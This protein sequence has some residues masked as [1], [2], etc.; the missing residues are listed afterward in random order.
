MSIQTNIK[1][2]AVGVIIGVGIMGVVLWKS[3]FSVDRYATVSL[4]SGGLM[5]GKI[6]RFPRTT[7][8]DPF[9]V[10]KDQE[11][12]EQLVPLR[13]APW[14]PKDGIVYLNDDMIMNWSY[15]DP[16]GELVQQMKAPPSQ[17]S[18][19]SGPS[20]QSQSQVSPSNAPLQ[21]PP[22]SPVR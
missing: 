20:P 13:A 16:A 18:Q 9:I 17:G 8:T 15:L 19:Q 12:R 22:K 3:V 10:I 4:S 5:F 2:I 6:S 7:L 11:G 21:P 1:L 14:A